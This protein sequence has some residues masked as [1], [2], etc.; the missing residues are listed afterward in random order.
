M[1]IIPLQNTVLIILIDHSIYPRKLFLI[2]KALL[3]LLGIQHINL[4]LF[5]LKY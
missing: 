3:R 4:L 2:L 1:W 5:I